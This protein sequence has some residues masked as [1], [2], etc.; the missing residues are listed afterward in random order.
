MSVHPITRMRGRAIAMALSGL[1]LAAGA[2]TAVAAPSPGAGAE[3]PANAFTSWCATSAPCTYRI[4]P[5]SSLTGLRDGRVAWAGVD[6]ELTPAQR[7]AA[8][9]PVAYYPTVVTGLVVATNVPGVKGQRLSL[10]GGAI[11]GIFSGAITNWNAGAIRASNHDVSLPRDLPITLCVPGV[12]SAESLD[13]TQYLS[14]VSPRFRAT[15]GTSALPK[16][17]GRAILLEDTV[18]VAECMEGNPGAISFLTMGDAVREGLGQQMVAVGKR[19]KVTYRRAKG[20]TLTRT[21]YVF[22]RPTDEAIRTAAQDAARRTRADLTLDTE[23]V[24][25]KG[26][27]PLTVE[28]YAVVRSDLMMSPAT[29]K[30]L[31]YFLSPRGQARLQGLGYVSIPAGLAAKAR[32]QLAAAR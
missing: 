4:G 2:G 3:L 7:R 18:Q 9:G 12:S 8:G 23:R 31:R 21:E 17:K 11:A 10:T 32:A 25:A 14:R 28:G 16:W 5:A 22:V 1:A 29:R 13:F 19:E 20:G 30:S 6:E 26:A 27:Y 24:S 15:I